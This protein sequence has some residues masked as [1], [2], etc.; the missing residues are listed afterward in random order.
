MFNTIYSIEFEF[1]CYRLSVHF[2]GHPM[3]YSKWKL[4][5]LVIKRPKTKRQ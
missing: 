1:V 5:F 4:L 2:P 3:T